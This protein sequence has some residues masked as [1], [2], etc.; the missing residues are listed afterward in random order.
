M[1]RALRVAALVVFAVLFVAF[2][3]GGYLSEL[4][5]AYR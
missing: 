4:V 3:G 2:F 1:I 5:G